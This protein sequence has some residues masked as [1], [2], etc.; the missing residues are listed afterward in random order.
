MEHGDVA[1]VAGVIGAVGSGLVL[2]ARGR[3]LLLVGLGTLAVTEA[4]LAWALVPAED[5]DRAVSSPAV[6]GA[7][8]FAAV[9]VALLAAVV[10]RY[11]ASAPVLLV[12]AAPFRFPVDVGQQRAFL[13]LPLYG[14]LAAGALALA[15]RA[16]RRNDLPA[17]LPLIAVP[18]A[19]LT[20]VVALS[21]LWTRDLKAGSIELAFFYFPFALLLAVVARAPL[22]RWTPRALAGGIVAL[23][24]VFAAVGVWQAWTKELFFAR[25]LE[26]ANAYSS[27]FRVTSLFKDPSIYGR[28]LVV[29]MVVILVALWLRRLKPVPAALLLGVLFAGLYFSYSQSSLVTLFVAAVAVTLVAGDRLARRAVLAASAVIAVVGIVVAA[30]TLGDGSLR[31]ATSGRSSLVGATATV[32]VNHP[33]AGVGIGSQ[34]RATRDEA[35]PEASIRRNASH[36]TPLT[37]AAEQ[38]LLGLSAYVAF[39]AGLAAALLSLWRRDRGLGLGLGALMLVL[40]VHSLFYSGFFQDPL[41]WGLAGIAAAAAVSRQTVRDRAAVREEHAGARAQPAPRPEQATAG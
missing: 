2:L 39:L 33:I 30:A 8:A 35:R 40:V 7:M 1:Q 12:L 20:V 38:G 5:I 14:A 25:D 10:V 18:A 9:L 27:F 34:A 4:L 17:P 36:T 13:L 29:A 3:V 31:S 16:L 26:V 23:G 24:L 41:T 19:A 32:F 21:I 15:W 22:Q 11:P 28:H 6:L 37:I